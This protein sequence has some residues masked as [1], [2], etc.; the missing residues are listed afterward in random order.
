MDVNAA[1][2]KL[3]RFFIRFGRLPT[4]TEIC[5][6]FKYSSKSSAYYLIKK[7]VGYGVLEKDKKGNLIPRRLFQIP[8]L[9]IIHAGYPSPA[10]LLSDDSVDLYEYLINLPGQV[11]SLIAKGD[12][13]IN[14]GITDGDSVIIE[15]DRTPIEGDVVAA[16]VDGDWTIK[17]FHRERNRVIL[18][19]ANS[20]YKPIAPTYDL[21]IGGVVISVH[22]KYH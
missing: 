20:K 18:M 19:P 7:L 14:A 9:G 15:K 13:M 11:F 8:R 17:H 4:Y 12:S 21:Q 6:M 3:R 22:R 10:E 5:Y 16:Y 2:P 1:I